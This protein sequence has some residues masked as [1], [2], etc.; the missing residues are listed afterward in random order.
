MALDPESQRLI[1]LMAAADRPAWNTLSPQAARDLYLSLR[2]G[3]QGPRPAD[4]KVIDRT[5]P[6]PAGDLPVR[7][8]RPASAAVDAALPALVYAHGGGWVFGNLDSHDVLCAQLSLEAG[9]AVFHVDYRLAPEARFPGAFDDVV[10]ALKWV[11]AHGASVGIDPTRLAIGGDSAGGNL[12]AAA[13][14]WAR[15]NGGPKLRM[16][17]LAYPVTDAV[18][19]TE[20]YRHFED[21]YGLNAVTMEWFFDHYTPDKASR[22]DWRV[23]PL[24]AAS[25]AGLPPALVVTAGYDPLRDEGRAYAWRLQQDGTQ[26]DLVEFGGMLHGFLSSPMLLHGA[27]RGTTLCA[28]ALREA[29][30]LRAQ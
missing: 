20:S 14:I 13:S 6:G 2:P 30:V 29:L 4:V 23:S 5:I 3:A 7:L 18:A 15:D 16:Q 10:A 19:R 1:D 27:R 11:A 25:L 9:I 17:L 28:A 22:G 8:Y 26:A 24:R 12:A 21:G